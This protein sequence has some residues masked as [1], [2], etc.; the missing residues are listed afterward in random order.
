MSQA[1]GK[2]EEGASRQDWLQQVQGPGVAPMLGGGVT[3]RG[4]QQL[5][6]AQQPDVPPPLDILL[7][8]SVVSW[9]SLLPPSKNCSGKRP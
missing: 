7:P 8:T 4:M 3:Q 9:E 1:K 5:P 2:G 6:G